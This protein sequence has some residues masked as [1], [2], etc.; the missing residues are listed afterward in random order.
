LFVPRPGPWRTILL[1]GLFMSLGQFGLLYVSLHLGMPAGL[2]SLLVQVQVIFSIGISRVVL[3][4]RPTRQQL[5]GVGICLAG[6]AVL[7]LGHGSTAGLLPLA[8]LIGACLTW[9]IGNV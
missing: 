4:E 9:S 5:I 6:L 1:V 8:V 7:V 3:K 2:A